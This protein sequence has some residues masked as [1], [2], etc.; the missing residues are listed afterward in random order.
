MYPDSILQFMFVVTVFRLDKNQNFVIN[1]TKQQFYMH[2][3]VF[4]DLCTCKIITCPQNP[5][6]KKIINMYFSRYRNKE[7]Q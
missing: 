6:C 4:L 3:S 1:V 5:C 2:T 7:V